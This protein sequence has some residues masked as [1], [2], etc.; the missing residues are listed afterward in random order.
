MIRPAWLVELSPIPSSLKCEIRQDHPLQGAQVTFSIRSGHG[1][2]S[3]RF[4][5][6]QATT[7]ADGRAE[8]RLTLGPIPGPTT[9]EVSVPGVES[10]TFHSVATGTPIPPAGDDHRTWNLPQAAVSRLGKGHLTRSPY[11]LAFS[12]HALAVGSNLGVWLYDSRTFVPLAWLRAPLDDA[13]LLTFSPD[14]TLLA[15]ARSGGADQIRLWNIPADYV[16]TTLHSE[17]LSSPAVFSPTE[18]TIAVGL[19]DGAIEI[20]DRESGQVLT[21]LQGH[22][23]AVHSLSF[24]PDGS[25]L[26]SGSQDRTMRLWDLKTRT[27][28][29][30]LGG[31]DDGIAT[32]ALTPDGAAVVSASGYRLQVWDPET[33]TNLAVLEALAY[34]AGTFSLSPDG[35]LASVSSEAIRIWDL[36]RLAHTS[37][38]LGHR[39]QITSLSFSRDGT[40]LASGSWWDGTVRLWDASTGSTLARIVYPRQIERLALSPDGT[41]LATASNDFAVTL[42]DISTGS[43]VGRMGHPYLIESVAFSPDGTLLASGMPAY[44]SDRFY[45]WD[46][47]TGANTAIL[48]E[49]PEWM[50]SPSLSPDGSLRAAIR[51]YQ[52]HL[53]DVVT[54]ARKASLV[55]HGGL[56]LGAAFSPDGTTIASASA[57]RT[58]KLWEVA[59]GRHISTLRGHAGAVTGV[60][61]L[62]DGTLVSGSRDGTVLFWDRDLA[63]APRPEALTQVSGDEQHELPGV[64]LHEPFVVEVRDENGDPFEGAQVTF[65]VTEG[66]GGLT[67]ETA[68]TDGQGRASSTLTL[69]STPGPNSVEATVAGLEPVT[70]TA[71]A[72]TAPTTLA[73]VAGDGQHGTVGAP[74]QDPLVVSVLDQTGAPLPGAVV[75]FRVTDGKGKV[76]ER[77]V[78]TDDRGRAATSLTLGPE[79]GTNT[80]QVTVPGLDPMTF[81]ATGIGIP[82]AISKV[83]GDGQEG[84]GGSQL[85]EPL[86]VSVLDRTGSALYGAVVTFTVTDGEGVLSA[87]TDTTDVRGHAS[88]TLTLGRQQGTSTV[89][90]TVGELEPVTFTATARTTPDFD[91]DGVVGLSDFFLFAE[92]FGGS[93]PRFDLDDNGHVDFTDFFLFAEHFGPPARSK[94][95]ALARERIDLPDG[96]R[97]QQN[98]PNPFNSQTVIPLFLLQGGPARVEV[99]ALTGQRVA[100]LHQGQTEAGFHRLHWDGRDDQGRLLASGVYVCRLVT[101]EAAQTRKLTLLR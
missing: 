89:E 29:G 1:K 10:V 80:V 51:G 50:D 52:V 14:G 60:L 27:T 18:A 36:E 87:T 33:G 22:D 88:T 75:I 58:V 3:N 81:T 74:L 44:I 57:D 16:Y 63:P 90:V 96:P 100:V 39:Y 48:E 85:Q 101:S 24:S 2:L 68:T 23:G 65:R 43:V 61:F 28:M 45:L 72:R 7:D 34:G 21:T 46:V 78:A 4:A 54:E 71:T 38:F 32:V 77:H 42:W 82:H 84:W 86:V 92:A 56:V 20:L 6:E 66:G 97:L 26:V 5:A 9:I 37:T 31:H 73:K 40:T 49:A 98:T 53:R 94:L 35:T 76:S 11:A 91:G 30:V 59:T 47:G 15:M 99:Y 8:A 25:M 41:L 13:T 83:S 19:R 93:D 17:G 69:G 12:P 55:G 95:L 79:P 62:P 64:A 70:F 67:T